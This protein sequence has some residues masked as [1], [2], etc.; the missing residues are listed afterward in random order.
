MVR[1]GI[2]FGGIY[3]YVADA[4]LSVNAVLPS[5]QWDGTVGSGFATVPVDPERT[6]AKPAMRMLEPPNQ[7]FTD[8]MVIG[9]S[10]MANN[11]G[12]MLENLGLSHVSVYF[13]GSLQHITAP[14]F[15]T[16]QDANGNAATYLGWWVTL[17]KPEGQGG[18]G[19][20]FLQMRLCSGA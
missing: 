13:E 1:R 5:Q 16:F 8:E 6:S 4:Q 19:N 14:S 10:A 17:K 9:V 18:L 3:R 7:Y 20:V 12:S 15:R 2:G 11:Q